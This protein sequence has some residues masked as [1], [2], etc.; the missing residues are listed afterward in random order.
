MPL[1]LGKAPSIY[2]EICEKFVRVELVEDVLD[3]RGF[4]VVLLPLLVLLV[5]FWFA[6]GMVLGVIFSLIPGPGDPLSLVT[7]TFFL[8]CYG[9]YLRVLRLCR[10]NL[11]YWVRW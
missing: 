6:V 11:L 7:L 1:R 3:D 10:P 8:C 4:P 2:V 9:K 5:P